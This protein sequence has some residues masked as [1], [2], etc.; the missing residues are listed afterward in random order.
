M[1]YCFDL[2]QRKRK[3]ESLQKEEDQDAVMA[4]LIDESANLNGQRLQCAIKIK[5]NLLLNHQI[6]I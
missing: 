1:K 4:N 5:V 6:S 2:D 3:L